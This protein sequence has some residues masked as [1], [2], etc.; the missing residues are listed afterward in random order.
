MRKQ[1]GVAAIAAG[2]LFVSGCGG[3]GESE[4]DAIVL[5]QFDSA[6][7]IDGL[8][9]AVDAWNAENPESPLELETITGAE[10]MRQYAREANSG[11]GPDIIQLPNA[12]VPEIAS[13]DTLLPLDDF[14]E[15]DPPGGPLDTYLATDLAVTDD[16]LWG[17]PWTVDTF[18]LTYRVD[19]FEDAGLEEP[20]STWEGLFDD[21]MSLT[22]TRDDGQEQH[23]F[24]FAA[25]SSEEASQWFAI[26]YYLWTKDQPLVEEQDDGS[27][28]TGV[29]QDELAAAIDY[30]DRYLEDGATAQGMTAVDGFS[31]PQIAAGLTNGTCAMT[32]LPPQTFREL[33]SASDA[34]IASAPMPGGTNDGASHLGGRMLGINPNTADP[35]AAWEVIKFLNSETAFETIDQYPANVD[36]LDAL[37]VPEG[38]EGYQEQLPHS[39]TFAR[40]TNSQIPLTAIQSIVNQEFGAVY[41]DQK[42]SEDAAAA[43]LE[44]LSSELEE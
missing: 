30:F 6:E 14:V 34:P 4:S 35:E 12:Q 18:A 38:E 41:T 2:I 39:V 1:I 44:T 17:L 40:Y 7:Q 26:N 32:Y 22:Q 27:W 43:I 15:S 11:S 10:A 33:Q 8:V 16:T 9:Q 24:C 13:E 21:A 5:R 25:S 23:G 37:D 29:T 31:D 42:S 20:S 3:S 28:S 36:V 19:L